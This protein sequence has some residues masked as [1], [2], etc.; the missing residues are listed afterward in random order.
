MD[1][2]P[3]TGVVGFCWVLFGRGL[4]SGWFCFSAFLLFQWE[5]TDLFWFM[6]LVYSRV[7]IRVLSMYTSVATRL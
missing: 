7:G 5:S 2:W 6:M 4:H 1:Y 3:G